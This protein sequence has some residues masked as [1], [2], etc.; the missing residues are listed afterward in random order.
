MVGA[1]GVPARPV[2]GGTGFEVS[3][4]DLPQPI[5]VQAQDDK[6]AIGL[7]GPS[8]RDALDPRESFADSESGKAVL[9]T[10]GDGYEPSFALV[11]GPMLQLVR[12]VG[13]DSDP[14]FQEALPYLTAYRSIAAGTKRADGRATVR[15]VAGLQ[16]PTP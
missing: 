11:L 2:S 13:A 3:V 6:V 5:V 15:I 8:T 12:A 7:G 9:D 4:P 1:L 14:E 16:E 10:L